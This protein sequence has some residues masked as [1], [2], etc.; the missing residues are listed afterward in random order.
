MTT[1]KLIS[2]ALASDC[3]S[4]DYATAR[5]R[6]LRAAAR[7]GAHLDTF[8]NDAVRGPDEGVLTTDVAVLGPA[9]ARRALLVISGTHG[10]EGFVGSAAQ[11]ALLEQL[12]TTSVALDARVVLVHAINPWG[13]AHT[14]RTTENG[15][16]LNR[17]FIEWSGGVP[18]NPLY[19]ELHALLFPPDW[20]PEAGSAT[21]NA[22]SDAW[23]EQHGR[24]SYVDATSKGQYTHSDGF[25]YGGTQREWSNL[26]LQAI[27][28]RHLAGAQQIALIDWHTG[29][30]ERGQPFFLCF[31]ERG[32]AAW[33]RACAWWGK[34]RVETRGGFDGVDRPA[35]TGLLF[36]GV[37]RFAP[38]AEITGAVIEFGTLPN[39]E[40]RHALQI[41]RHLRLSTDLLPAER[42]RMREQLADAFSPNS[43]SWQRST[44]THAIQI[45]HAA[46][47]GL[48][49][50]D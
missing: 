27:V 12:A 47:G 19:P 6:F 33:Q 44:L 24:A 7:A 2:G 50:W 48:Q 5:A 11:I 10:P 13:F 37:R 46:L 29:L 16:D 28:E 8:T 49:L 42:D 9:D 14:V 31:N 21:T 34:D 4:P 26:T 38:Q 17:N 20:R 35:Y 32:G 18:A 25:H 41:E 3:F 39:D 15:V 40:M 1:E 43:L 22:A 45:Q 23:I 36:D 30:G